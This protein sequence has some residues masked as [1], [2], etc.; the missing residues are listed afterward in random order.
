MVL[1]FRRLRA[2]SDVCKLLGTIVS[3]VGTEPGFRYN[4]LGFNGE[5]ILKV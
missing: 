4:D 3:I 2:D 5:G 1:T